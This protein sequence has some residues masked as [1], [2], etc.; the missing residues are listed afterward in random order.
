MPGALAATHKLGDATTAIHNKMG[1]NTQFL[2]ALQGWV[3]IAVQRA[4]KKFMYAAW[5]E[6]SRRQADGMQDDQA[7]IDT[8]RACIVMWAG[9]ERDVSHRL[10]MQCIVVAV[11]G[12]GLQVTWLHLASANHCLVE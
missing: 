6:L 10:M 5:V 3:E 4:E 8:C 2:Q 12:G 11:T 1:G 7:D 9:Q